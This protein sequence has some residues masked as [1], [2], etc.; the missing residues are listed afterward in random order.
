MFLSDLSIRRPIMISMLLVVF[1]IFGAISWFSLNLNSMPEVE[2]PYVSVMTI[3]PGAGPQEIETQ[4]TKPLEDAIATISRVKKITSYSLEAVSYVIIEFDLGKSVDL[5]NQEVKDKTNQVLNELPADAEQ[6]VVAKF[7]I[8]AFPVIDLLL[9]GEIPQTELRYLAD[10]ML[11]DRLSQVE[12]AAQVDVM[13]GQVREIQVALDNRVLFRN[14]ISLPQ[15]VGIIAAQNMNMPGGQ[16]QIDNQEMAVRLR[17]EISDLDALR[18]LEVPTASGPKRLGQIA[19]IND[20]HADVRERTTYFDNNLKKRTEG[21]IL[22]SIIKSAD[23]NTVN[24]AE[25]VLELIPK[26]NSEL[27]SGCE[28]RIIQDNSVYVVSTVN[29]TMSNVWLGVLFTGLVLLFFLHDW[30]SALIVGLAMPMSLISTLLLVRLFGYSLN[31]MTLMGLSTSVGILVANSVVVLENIFRHKEMGQNSRISAAKGTSEIAVAVIASA[32]TNLVV[33]LPIAAMAGLVGRFF[34]EFAMT[35]TFATLFSLLISFTLTPMLAAL[36]LPDKDTKKR[37]IGKI[38][39][40]WFSSW[41]RL[42]GTILKFLLARKLWGFLLILM[43]LVVFMLSM[44]LGGNV[45]FEFFPNM[46]EGV[47][48]IEVELPEGY[49]LDETAALLEQIES[50][51][52]YHP[53]ITHVLTRMGNI[54][55]LDVGSNLARMQ[56]K[57]VDTKERDISPVQLAGLMMSDVADLPN[58]VIRI[59]G[60]A[61]AGGPEEAPIS[62]SLQGQELETLESYAA[63]LLQGLEEIEGL[64]NLRTGSRTGKPEI[65]LTPNRTRLSEAGLTVYDL[66]MVLRSSVEGLVAT[67][68]REAGREYD[69][70]VMLTDN[71]CDTPEEIGNLTVVSPLGNYRLAQLCDISFTAGFSKITREDK[72]R[73]VSFMSDIAPGYVLGDLVNEIDQVVEAMDLPEGYQSDWGGSAEMMQETTRDMSQT[74]LIAIVLTYMLLAAI[75]ESFVQPLLILGTVP[76]ALI[77]VLVAMTITGKSFNTISMMAIIMLVGLV[78]NNGILLLDYTNILRKRGMALKEA[79]IEACPT[80]LKA[81][82]MATVAIVLGM[83]PLAMGLGDAGRE[84]R[85]PMG[86]VAIGGLLSSTLMGLLLIPVVYNLFSRSDKSKPVPTIDEEG[87]VR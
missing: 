25:G 65:E 76:L 14:S 80:K 72:S 12:G 49:N 73:A 1:L 19:S 59:S 85:Q 43:T 31:I 53:E 22:L 58:A 82:I 33:F 62:F 36:I 16:F 29:D 47:V 18:N 61:S 20:G 38:L 64:V 32:S 44:S 10:N 24:L 17:G 40:G 4:V 46:D 50:R 71:S 3:Y 23:G 9:T 45:G 54:G 30:R 27:P 86:I 78:V 13:G 11:V 37:R 74:L 48:N 7:D 51:I 67:R 70:R 39:E 35:V 75:L 81:I 15:L 6:P 41:E 84:I 8:N 21:A 57:L 26:L 63:D 79:L 77:G 28:L 69:L 83:L 2:I 56:L 42:Y 68:Y 34:K 60:A 52:I 66:A 55:S 87:G 5:A